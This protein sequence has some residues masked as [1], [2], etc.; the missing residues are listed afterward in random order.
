M[1]LPLTGIKILDLTWLLPYTTILADFGAEVIKIEEPTKGDY[2]RQMPPLIGGESAYF[3]NV[4]RNKKSMTLN[5]KTE[6]GREIFYKLA[7]TAD[8]I[9]ESFRPQVKKRLSIDYETVRNV[10]PRIIYCSISGYGQSGPYADL[11]GHDIN[12]ISIA[13]V[14]GLTGQYGGPP[15]IP[16]VQIA[17]I[18]GCMLATISILIALI[19]R[20]RTGEGQYVDISLTDGALF[21]LTLYTSIFFAEGKS[22]ERGGILQTGYYPCYNIYETRDGKYI[23]IGCV[24]ERFWKNLCRA[25]G[26]EDFIEHQL[27][28]GR[29]REEIF[30]TLREIFKT[31]SRDEWFKEL[32]KADVCVAPV[33]SLDEVFKD[34]QILHRKMV[35]EI[36]HPKAGKIKVLGIPIKLSRTPGSIREPAPSLGQHTREILKSLGYNDEEIERFRKEGII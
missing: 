14:L 13:G 30:S 18:M 19:E 10:N 4:H 9:V 27:A 33:Y 25:L 16:G 31:K 2:S 1:A 26:R 20:E 28:S 29:K 23:S 36:E 32:A 12:Y 22:P 17:D 7:S 6:K 5:L 15:I 8:V 35:E 11:A 34:P 21:S 24:E 3:L